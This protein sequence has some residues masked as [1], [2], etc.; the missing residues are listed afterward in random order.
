[1]LAADRAEI[2]RACQLLAEPGQVCELRAL[3][4][5]TPGWRRPHTVAGYFDDPAKLAAAAAGIQAR[6][7][8]MTLNPVQPA[9]LARAHN[10]VKDCGANE[11]L[12][13]DADILARRWLP[14]DCDAVRPTGI[15]ATDAER[16]LALARARAIQEHLRELGWPDPLLADSGN[17]GHLLYRVDLP[18]AER[19]AS[20]WDD[21]LVA[22]VLRSLAFLFDDEQ[23]LVDQ[24]VAN[25]A[26]IWKLY[27]TVVRKGDDTPERPHR[28]A[29]LLEAPEILIPVSREQLEA[30]AAAP[31]AEP[32]AVR[33]AT[34]YR[35]GGAGKGDFDL[36]AWIATHGLTVEGPRKWGAQG[37]QG[38]ERWI[39]PVCP[40][41]PAHRRSAYIVRFASGALAAG[42]HHNSCRTNDW[43]AL[44]LKVEGSRLQ[45]DGSRSQVADAT[46]TLQTSTANP[47]PSTVRSS[48]LNLE[49]STTTD[50]ILADLD[51]LRPADGKPDR[52]A[53][54]ARAAALVDR[55]AGLGKAD[56]LRAAAA[57]RGLGCTVEFTRRW[58]AAVAHARETD[59][60]ARAAAAVDDPVEVEG[61]PYAA[62]DRRIYRLTY[63]LSPEGQSLVVKRAIVADFTVRIVEEA[64]G[65]DGRTWFTLQGQTAAGRPFTVE[66]STDDFADDRRLQA[67]LTQ[68]AGARSPVRA[69]MAG[70]LRPAIQLLTT[71]ELRH[72]RR[73]ERTGWAEVEAKVEAKPESEPE[74]QPEPQSSPQPAFLIPG[75]E[76][77]GVIVRL[78]RK[79]PYRLDR[80]AD[81][82]LGLAAF[83]AALT[84]LEPWRTTVVAAALFQA[85]LARLAGWQGE[86]YGI[87]ITGRTG[88]LKT[89]VT[90][91]LLAIYGAGFLQ[92]EF[93][94]KLGEGATRNAIMGY[95]TQAH[96]LPFFLDN[97]KANTGDGG[98]GLVN[99]I[100]NLL[101]GGDRERMLGAGDVKE[102]RP[103]HCWPV[104]TGEDVPA[105]DPA[106]L[107]RVLVVPFEW[108]HGA[109]NPR[110]TAA[111]AAS[112]HLPAVGRAWLDWLASAAGREVAAEAGRQLPALRRRQ[113]AALRS[114][115]GDMIN[116]LR[117][118]TNLATNALT[119]WA[120]GQ[121]PQL[122][123]LAVRY[124]TEHAAGLAR[125][126]EEMAE[127]TSQALE[128]IRFLDALRGLLVSGRC[129]LVP[130]GEEAT[131]APE[132]VIGWQAE[133]G[134]A[135]L[136]P[137]LARAA[138]E[139]VLGD[140]GLNGISN[141][142]LYSQLASLGLLASQDA[143][144]R[145]KKLRAGPLTGNVL[146]LTAA[147]LQ[148]AGDEFEEEV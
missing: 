45:V 134:S 144:R 109:D 106:T 21:G 132:R 44:R 70:H 92:D 79:L 91:A 42:C 34:S 127:R 110:L 28:L 89:S 50:E 60:R 27:G 133:D 14:V 47:E 10:R 18:A 94:L 52:A 61:A 40:W 114:L 73:F 13:G 108:P 58:Q 75:R 46:A 143:D 113:V 74:P 22:R 81:L 19:A 115:R 148:E 49:P 126:A 129:V 38:A 122:G 107:A 9:L 111:Q 87:F 117:V 138:A 130:R 100:H 137:A 63:G 125:V 78:P 90:Q 112:A 5:V 31:P 20:P 3:D 136:A 86:R 26:R 131:V 59:R 104:F 141:Q 57:L 48:T 135:Y 15:S 96:D 84:S 51:S 118:A 37:A 145:T 72:V 24:T 66:L 93:L 32:L 116:P 4:A 140:D 85:P 17:G 39:F 120:L 41:N 69:G 68:A 11:A 77:S 128:A 76:P 142:A 29:R 67:A 43:R 82:G 146:H 147:A 2:L 139:A 54:E 6:G 65:E 53:V 25:P 99:L 33:A 101:E 56:L 123:P 7:V 124:A 121:H 103:I 83:E 97:F 23:S 119:W 8:Y 71:G 16:D 30:L 35:T 105:D 62:D 1:M 88:C 55:C 12:T 95:A 64:R 80:G 98:R 36:V 102:S